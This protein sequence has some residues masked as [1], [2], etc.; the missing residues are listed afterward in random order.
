MLRPLTLA[1]VLHL[2]HYLRFEDGHGWPEAVAFARRGR[3]TYTEH[4]DELLDRMEV[5]DITGDGYAAAARLVAFA[6]HDP[7][8]RERADELRARAEERSAQA[9]INRQEGP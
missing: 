5:E 9:R 2:S 4:R 3:V 8:V 7:K 6:D 1:D